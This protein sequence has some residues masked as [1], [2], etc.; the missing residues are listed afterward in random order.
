[1]KEPI[2]NS[3]S[4]ENV[5]R[6]GGQDFERKVK[7]LFTNK[8]MKVYEHASLFISK[9]D[10]EKDEDVTEQNSS[11]LKPSPSSSAI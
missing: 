11:G 9:R 8:F 5:K 4:G 1:M 10:P 7:E 2:P 3:E 6:R